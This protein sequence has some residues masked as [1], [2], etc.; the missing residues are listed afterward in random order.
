MTANEIFEVVL[1]SIHEVMSGLDTQE[2]TQ[3]D[4]LEALGANSVE[5]SDIVMLCLEKLNL[6]IP[7]VETFGPKNIGE[8]VLL[9][10]E[11][12]Q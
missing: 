2:I 11:K 5:R 12:L 6:N 1:N 3:S 10:D 4:S 9:F 8:L 7:L